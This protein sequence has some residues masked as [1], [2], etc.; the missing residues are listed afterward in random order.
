MICADSNVSDYWEERRTSRKFS[1]DRKKR[2]RGE[3][4]L[5]LINEVTNGIS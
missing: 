3:Y 1:S 5:E 2:V 4:I